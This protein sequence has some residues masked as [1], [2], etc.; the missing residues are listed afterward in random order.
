MNKINIT[1]RH[2]LTIL[3]AAG[4]RTTVPAG[5]GDARY[6]DLLARAAGTACVS[7]LPQGIP[8]ANAYLVGMTSTLPTGGSSGGRLLE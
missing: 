6:G 3:F 1:S 2:V 4:A 7:S 5:R 8:N